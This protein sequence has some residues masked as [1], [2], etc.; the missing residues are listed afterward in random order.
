MMNGHQMPINLPE[1]PPEAAMPDMMKEMEEMNAMPSAAELA[2]L[3]LAAMNEMV[4]A[5]QMGGN[6]VAALQLAAMTEMGAMV[7]GVPAQKDFVLNPFPPPPPGLISGLHG[8]VSEKGLAVKFQT[9]KGS[10]VPVRSENLFIKWV[11][12]ACG[13]DDIRTLFKTCG[14]VMSIKVLGD[15]YDDGYKAAMV[16]M[17]NA[18]EAQRAIFSLNGHCMGLPVGAPGAQAWQHA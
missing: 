4:A 2:A 8:G 1:I 12:N 3:Q 13:E 5:G 18:D 11:P 16:R 10:N 17:G 7:P 6:E 14:R 15:S 9:P